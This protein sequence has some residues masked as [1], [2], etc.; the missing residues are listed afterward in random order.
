MLHA[1]SDWSVREAAFDPSRLPHKETVFTI[2]NGYLSTRGAFEE[3]YPG[4]SPATLV[5]G[6]FDEAP[7]VFRELVNA[8]DWLPL[9]VLLNGE[10]FSLDRGQILDYERTL[11]LRYGVLTR[12]VRWRSL[13]GQ[14]V[15]FHFERFASLADAHLLCQRVSV[16]PL[17]FSGEIEIRGEINGDANTLGRSH[18]QWLEQ[19]TSPDTAWLRARTRKSDIEIALAMRLSFSGTGSPREEGWDVENHPTLVV[20]TWAEKGQ[21]VT[22]Q[23]LVTVFTSRDG[24]EPRVSAWA[25]LQ[26]VAGLEWEELLKANVEAWDEEWE[27]ADIVV[28]GDADAQLALRFNIFQLLIAGP[29][30]DDRVSIGGHTLSGFGYYGHV[31]WDTEI[32]MLPFFTYT[33]PH[34]ARNLLTYRWRHLPAARKYAEK[35]GFAG[36]RFPWESADTGEEVTPPWLPDW[37][38]PSRLVRIWTGDLELHISSD[39][40]YAIWQY[41]LASGDDDFMRER[42]A[43]VIL[44]TARFWAERAEW[45]AALGGYELKDVIGPDEYHE[46]V[47]NDAFT[48][49]LVRWHLGIALL[50]W[51]WLRKQ[52]PEVA[53][54]LTRRLDLNPARLARWQ[55]VRDKMYLPFD[56]ATGL[57]EQFSGY[58]GRRDV[59]L[60]DYEPR[61]TSLQM[62]LGS[63]GVSQTQVIKQP[64]VL[65]LLYL[66]RDE[67][68]EKTLRAN[69]DYYTPRTDYR[70]GS[71]LGPA[72]QAILACEVG[73]LD[74][75]YEY[76][77]NAAQMDLYDLR[78]NTKHGIHGAAAGGAWQ[79]AVFG[80]GGLKVRENGWTVTSRLPKKWKSLNFRFW[81]RGK[82]E[83]IVLP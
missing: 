20:R 59:K 8:P 70:F 32:F 6:V 79:A 45:N 65:I 68:D 10:R 52:A 71:S 75:A 83:N 13:K 72:V 47:D 41:W 62:L 25:R 28:E 14:T 34:I 27:S 5:A 69:Y 76:F 46:H 37:R 73:D 9:I 57:I 17:D 54:E 24:G 40:A 67:F 38:D 81:Y 2:G 31:F 42:G 39:I 78:G 35:G 61:D 60:S 49:Y 77:M 55:E 22:A 18:W 30:T 36:A 43:E 3:G 26:P 19:E 21:T 29:R 80:F 63:E 12:T 11:D 7:F 74:T 15:E 58:F 16:T 53:E 1:P 33:R 50:L 66:L 44:D 48:N 4:D 23:K 82:L 64:D 56:P 51:D